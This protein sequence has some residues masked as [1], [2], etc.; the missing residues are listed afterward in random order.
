M[1]ARVRKADI[2]I[3]RRNAFDDI[4]PGHCSKQGAICPMK[5]NDFAAWV[6]L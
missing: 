1:R 2:F 4:M 3:A 5:R 6:N